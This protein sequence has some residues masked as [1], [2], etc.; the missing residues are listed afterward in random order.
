MTI[1][2]QTRGG[3]RAEEKRNTHRSIRVILCKIGS[4]KRLA[5][6][7]HTRHR[8]SVL[9]SSGI[10]VRLP[11]VHSRKHATSRTAHVTG[12]GN[13]PDATPTPLRG[14]YLSLTKIWTKV[15]R[16]K[17]R[18]QLG[19]SKRRIGTALVVFIYFFPQPCACQLVQDSAQYQRRVLSY[20][21]GPRRH[22]RA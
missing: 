18:I 22:P 13:H 10:L 2:S 7:P 19:N 9:T 11:V 14:F 5:A 6:V 21:R 16:T 17:E 3:G 12:G 20:A 4:Y 15:L 8:A 1:C